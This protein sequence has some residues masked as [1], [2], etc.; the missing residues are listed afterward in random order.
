MNK[1]KEEMIEL[2]KQGKTLRE[3]AEIYGISKQWVYQITR[4]AC[5]SNADRCRKDSVVIE[6]IVYRGIYELFVND[7]KMTTVKLARIIY[8]VKNPSNNQKER[9][10]HLIFNLGEC[11]LTLRNIRNI[12]D[13]ANKPFEYVFEVRM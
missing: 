5:S 3:I 13:Y 6:N 2:R 7:Y 1:N 11:K 9:I 8:G 4:D 12:C 10:R